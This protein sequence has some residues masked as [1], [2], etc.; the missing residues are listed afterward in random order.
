MNKFFT[1]LEK[2]YKKACK[3]KIDKETKE[4]SREELEHESCALLET[5]A[6]YTHV[7]DSI[8]FAIREGV[9]TLEEIQKYIEDNGEYMIVYSRYGED[10]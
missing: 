2:T 5:Q 1:S 9:T 10:E 7:V 6:N 4:M 8:L 3:Y